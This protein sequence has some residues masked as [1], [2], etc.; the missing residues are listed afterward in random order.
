MASAVPRASLGTAWTIRLMVRGCP[1]PRKNPATT[2]TA[3]RPTAPFGT[4][5]AAM[6]S[7]EPTALTAISLTRPSARTIQGI[8]R[9][10]RIDATARRLSRVPT[11]AGPIPRRSPITGR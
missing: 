8:S 5:R 11:T 9:R 7:A 6:A 4:G 10:D 2:R 3:A 1:I